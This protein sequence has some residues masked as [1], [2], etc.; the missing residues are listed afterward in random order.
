LADREAK[1]SKIDASYFAIANAQRNIADDDPRR[2]ELVS[3]AR[4]RF[5]PS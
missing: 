4:L 5:Q 1:K 3:V 2:T